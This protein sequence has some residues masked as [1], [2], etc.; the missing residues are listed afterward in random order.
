[1]AESGGWVLVRGSQPLSTN[2]EVW[3]CAKRFL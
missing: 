2:L 1:M 3:G